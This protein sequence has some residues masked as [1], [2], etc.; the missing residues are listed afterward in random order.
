M[1]LNLFIVICIRLLLAH[2]NLNTDC[3]FASFW[4]I[5]KPGTFSGGQ[6]RVVE[7]LLFR[8]GLGVRI[9][10]TL[11]HRS[12]DQPHFSLVK[13]REIVEYLLLSYN[14]TFLTP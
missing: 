11:F 5:A 12:R 4:C 8:I 14:P 3:T 10:L 13:R 9:I 1:V 6:W 7:C 2:E